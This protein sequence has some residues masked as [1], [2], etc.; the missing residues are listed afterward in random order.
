MEMGLALVWGKMY[1]PKQ[2]GMKLHC[3]NNILFM[4]VHSHL[5]HQERRKIS[6]D[7]NGF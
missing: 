7:T 3:D 5:F 1:K 4:N 2:F 6:C